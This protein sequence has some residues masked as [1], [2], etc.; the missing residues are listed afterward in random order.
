MVGAAPAAI[1]VIDPGG[2]VHEWNPSAETL[3]QYPREEALGR[4]LAELIVPPAL[5]EAHR[6]G[7]RRYVETREPTILG[8]PVELTAVRRDGTEFPVELTITTLP[9]LE[10][11]MSPPSYATGPPRARSAGERPAAAAHG[12]PRATSLVLDRS[13]DYNETLRNL[14]DLTV[15]ELAQLT[16][17]DLLGEDA[18]VR[19][20]VAAAEDSV[21]AREI[22]QM[23]DAHPLLLTGTH[24]VATVLR[25]AQAVLLP[26]M[27]P[28]FLRTIAADP[29]HFELMRRLRYH[30]AIVVPLIARRRALG[31]LSLLRM[32]GSR[33]YDQDDLVLAEELARRAAMAIDNAR[34]FEATQHVARTLQESLLPR[35]LP[36]IP[37]VRIAGRYRAAAEAQEVG[38][39]FYDAFAIADDRWGIVIGDV[40]GKGPEAA[41]LTALARYTIRAVADAGPAEVLSRPNT[42]VLRQGEGVAQRFLTAIVAVAEPHEGMLRVQIAA[43]GHPAPLVLRADGSV[44]A[45][46]AWGPLV[47]VIPDLRY[48]HTDCL[49][50][51]GDTLVLYTDGLTDARAPRRTLTE[52]DVAEMLRRGHGMGA[53]RLAAFLEEQATAG[54]DP[55][56]DIALLVIE[57][58]SSTGR[59]EFGE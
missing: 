14:A 41:G 49:L 40:C 26:S 36:V 46:D 19:S 10:P 20:A 38:G 43:G 21:R 59:H 39:D 34:L 22:E 45:V 3:F 32:E 9:E 4:E 37:G 28:S 24:P 56:D 53:D 44:E 51:P 58:E 30:S 48:D 23:R 42:T 16:V 52:D 1:I 29:E 13:L 2:S 27:T 35:S 33:S 17:I 57:L 6:N 55:R 7:L 11:P 25:S 8:R 12:L 47:G 18:V 54:V 15:P 50:R 5:R 31:T